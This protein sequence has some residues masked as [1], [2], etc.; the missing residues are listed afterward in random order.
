MSARTDGDFLRDMLEHAERAVSFSQGRSR[1]ELDL[2][3]EFC[4]ALQ[5]CIMVIGEAASK[6]S[7]AT[8]ARLPTVAW[9]EIIG[10]RQWIVHRYDRVDNAILWKTATEDIPELIEQILQFLPPEQT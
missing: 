8:K 1:G 2:D 4:Y 7:E 5:H 10:M 3:Y 9:H 6:V